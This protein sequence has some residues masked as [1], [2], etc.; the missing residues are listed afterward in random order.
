MERENKIGF[1]KTSLAL[2]ES[3]AKDMAY[4]YA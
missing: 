1:R 4:Q 3:R 2:Q